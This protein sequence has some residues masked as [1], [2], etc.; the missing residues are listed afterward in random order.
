MSVIQYFAGRTRSKT[1]PLSCA[2]NISKGSFLALIMLAGL[3]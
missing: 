2:E 3:Q 1:A